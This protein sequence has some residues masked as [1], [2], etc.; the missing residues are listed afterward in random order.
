MADLPQIRERID[1]VDTQI[2]DLFTRRMALTDEVAAY[3]AERGLP[4]LDRAR[5]RAKI[6]EVSEAAPEGVRD[7]AVV[8][9]NLLM[10]VS[11]ANQSTYVSGNA[12]LVEAIERARRDTPDL[13]PRTAFVACQGVEGAYSQLAADKLFKHAD[14]SF[15][16]T[17]EGVFKAV[18]Q[19]F[20]QYGVLPF[21]NSTAGTVNQVYDLMGAYDFHIV[22]TVRLKVDHNL[23]AKPGCTLEGVTDIY[24]HQQAID[25]CAD[26]L[27]SL[28]GVTVHMVE[29]TAVAAKMV[30]DGDNPGAAALGSRSAAEVYGL[31]I[32][33]R[34]VQ[35]LGNNYT[36]FACISKDLEV[37]P[38]ADR[39][40]LS[41][42]VANR[43]GSLYK[44]LARFYSLDI[45]LVKLES[46]P[47][48]D[49]DFDYLFYFDVDCPVAAPEFMR[50][51]GSLDDVCE[52]FR[53]L[54]S[55]SEEV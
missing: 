52:E 17:F 28:E 5:E 45:N 21:E 26:F 3:K 37:Y 34:A 19:G 53:Y 31:D 20:C 40:S 11:R 48:P 33:R 14:L 6:A 1:A 12:D 47:L 54:G 30:A 46:R 25:Q 13:F 4:V 42:V 27:A 18:D 10:E 55:Y 15:F 36:R 24:S 49:R 43:P 39:T 9:F 50:L 38:G 7:Y 32:V 2:L 51:I 23:L 29:N 16:S 35:D 22:R 8:L 44:V 41:A